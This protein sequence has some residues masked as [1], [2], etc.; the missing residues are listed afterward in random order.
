MATI[1]VM[2][3][4]GN[5]GSKVVEQLRGKG[6]HVRALGRTAG[7]L[8]GAQAKGAEVLLGDAGNAAFLTEAF[9]GA[10][11]A[12]TLLPPNPVSAHFLDDMRRT[13]EAIARAAADAGLKHLVALSS[14]GAD[15]PSGTGPIAGL[16]A[17]EQRLRPLAAHGVNVLVLRPGYFFENTLAVLG[18]IKHQGINGSAMASD[19][20][21]PMIATADI[22]DAA[23]RALDARDWTGFQ[24]RE[25]LGPRDYTQAEVT[26]IIGAAIGRPDL[27]YVRFPYADYAA[28]LVQAGLSENVANL[29]AEMERALDDGIVRS[30]EGRSA[31]NTTPT[32]FE[33]FAER[34][35]APAYAAG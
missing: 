9:R 32:T 27:S 4:N 26:R 34:V 7:K 2:G 17:H 29:Y 31:A 5:I 25:L 16:H 23:A 20:A 35:L 10:D 3:A 6:H 18:L 28:A 24:V 19:T 11:G 1:A 22:A 30:V 33:Q 12:F 14:V 13:G 8:A 21:L 15:R